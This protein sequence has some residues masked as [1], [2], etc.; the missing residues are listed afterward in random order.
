MQKRWDLSLGVLDLSVNAIRAGARSLLISIDEPG[1]GTLRLTVEDDGRGMEED[2]L[3]RAA[4]PG[5]T[6]RAS[7]EGGMGLAWAKALARRTGGRFSLRSLPQWG[8]RVELLIRMDH[9]EAPPFGE[10]AETIATLLLTDGQ[11]EVFYRHRCGDR[12][13]HC[14]TA[15]EKL[16]TGSEAAAHLRIRERLGRE[17]SALRTPNL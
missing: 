14:S 1:D 5:F 17:L 9:S 11:T 2:V 8:T 4:D 10:M 15:A 7:G 16:Q 3:R 13:L 6:T 12:L